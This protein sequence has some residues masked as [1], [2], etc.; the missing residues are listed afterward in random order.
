MLLFTLQ[1]AE[2]S[3]SEFAT[4]SEPIHKIQWDKLFSNQ[5]LSS[6]GRNILDVL[7]DQGRTG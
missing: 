4:L 2:V 3:G 5:I 6:H 7:T 1:G